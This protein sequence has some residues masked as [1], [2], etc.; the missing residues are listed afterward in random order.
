M[1]EK[2]DER[3]KK[4]ILRNAIKCLTCQVIIESISRN[5]FKSCSCG[6]VSLDGGLDYLQRSYPPGKATDYF[7]ELSIWG[8]RQTIVLICI[9]QLIHYTTSTK[10]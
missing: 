6:Y 2:N 7:E 9:K 4:R 3:T 5:D 10:I 1:L 8:T